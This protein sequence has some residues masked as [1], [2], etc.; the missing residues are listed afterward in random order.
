VV[1]IEGRGPQ[2]NVLDI[3]RA[4][5]LANRHR[6]LP[7]VVPH[8]GETIRFGIEAGDSRAGALRSVN[9][10]EGEIRLQELA[11]LDHVLLTLA[12]R[13]DRKR[14]PQTCPEMIGDAHLMVETAFGRLD[15]GLGRFGLEGEGALQSEAVFSGHRDRNSRLRPTR[16]VYAVNVFALISIMRMP[17]KGLGLRY[18]ACGQSQYRLGTNPE[19]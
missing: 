2:D 7:R 6:R 4:V 5:A 16:S 3:E 19:K 8:G 11:V 1:G 9:I 18:I 14:A 10:E 15:A 12:F 13:H 17:E